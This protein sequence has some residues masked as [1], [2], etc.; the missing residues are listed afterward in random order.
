MKG[1]RSR[2]CCTS[3]SVVRAGIYK[4]RTV[5]VFR[6]GRADRLCVGRSG[7][8]RP[9][10]VSTALN[11]GGPDKTTPRSGIGWLAGVGYPLGPQIPSHLFAYNQAAK[12]QDL[13]ISIF[14]KNREWGMM[15][16]AGSLFAEEP[17]RGPGQ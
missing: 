15:I 12:A 16:I 10:R 2:P 6:R 1:R 13:N 14:G 17:H 8:R 7:H 11:L 5:P 9:D 4:A 3:A